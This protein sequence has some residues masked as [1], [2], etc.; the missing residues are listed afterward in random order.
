MT[1]TDAAFTGSIPQ[2][3]DRYLAP[4]L[5]T[6]FAEDMAD[7]VA[8]LAPSQILETAAGTGLATIA[9]F[10]RLPTA[11]LT[12][13]DL[14]QAMLNVASSRISS[15]NVKIQQ[16]DAQSLPFSDESFDIVVC[17][18]GMMF[19]PDRAA[20]YSEA[21]RVLKSGGR[22]IFN[23][24]NSLE[25]NPVPKTVADAV[26]TLF[27]A[28]PP[29]FFSRVPW[30]YSDI[31]QLEDEVLC[32]GFQSVTV[33]T[34]EKR[35][36]ATSCEEAAI[37]LCQGTPLRPEIEAR[38]DLEYVTQMAAAALENAFGVGPINQPMSARVITA[39]K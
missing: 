29:T 20:G 13:T 24:W 36:L 28:D 37:G 12:A 27:A 4:L 1:S 32:G 2:I 34:I 17:Q 25:Q 5:F 31:A 21:N 6:P 3:Y 35:S 16:A 33:N 8:M 38:G 39:T 7:R 30:G 18:F 19:L 10:D 11:H 22:F 15:S 14:N 26:T 9:I 23:V